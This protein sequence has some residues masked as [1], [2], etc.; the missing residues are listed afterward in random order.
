MVNSSLALDQL[1]QLHSPPNSEIPIKLIPITH[2]LI[3]VNT[4]YLM[5]SLSYTVPDDACTSLKVMG[6]ASHWQGRRIAERIILVGGD[7]CSLE[8]K[9]S[10]ILKALADIGVMDNALTAIIVK[11]SADTLPSLK[12]EGANIMAK[13]LQPLYD[14]PILLCR[15]VDFESLDAKVGKA[16]TIHLY[17]PRNFDQS[18]FVMWILATS[19]VYLSAIQSF[20]NHPLFAN[21]EDGWIDEWWSAIVLVAVACSLALLSL[22]P[23][24]M[25][26]SVSKLLTCS[27]IITTRLHVCRRNST[28]LLFSLICQTQS[29][30]VQTLGKK[31]YTSDSLTANYTRRRRFLVCWTVHC[32]VVVHG[33][34]G[35]ECMVVAGFTECRFH[36]LDCKIVS[37]SRFN[38]WCQLGEHCVDVQCLLPLL[39]NHGRYFFLNSR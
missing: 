38:H 8:T 34:N 35:N 18:L 25:C 28:L 36:R 11:Y 30:I 7:G 6:P 22:A 26:T 3:P 5:G 20:T 27:Q 39:P 17:K 33:T 9:S 21:S 14:I 29:T 24:L 10:N 15:E 32:L 37:C 16:A 2:H 13:Q 19:V 1:A 31:H 4:P 12:L 23:T